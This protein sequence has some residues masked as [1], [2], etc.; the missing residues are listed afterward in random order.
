MNREPNFDALNER[1]PNRNW[2]EI[3]RRICDGE[4][5]ASSLKEAIERFTPKEK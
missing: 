5:V 1:L 2:K 3:Y 4:P